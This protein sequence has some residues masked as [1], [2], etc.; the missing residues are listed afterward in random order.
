MIVNV[1]TMRFFATAARHGTNAT[2]RTEAAAAQRSAPII[3]RQPD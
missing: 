1:V 3:L 2:K